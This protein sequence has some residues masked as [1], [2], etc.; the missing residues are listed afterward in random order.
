MLPVTPEADLGYVGTIVSLVCIEKPYSPLAFLWHLSRV[1]PSVPLMRRI[2]QVDHDEE[3]DVTDD[4]GE[5]C[6]WMTDSVYPVRH[7]SNPIHS[8]RD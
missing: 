2:P 1:R 4:E 5:A 3:G 6:C 8:P 7:S